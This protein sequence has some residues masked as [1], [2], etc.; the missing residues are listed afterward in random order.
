MNSSTAGPAGTEKGGLKLPYDE[1]C[2]PAPLTSIQDI[3]AF[4]AA[5]KEITHHFPKP[6]RI[7]SPLRA[8]EGAWHRWGIA[9][10]GE[11]REELIRRA[12]ECYEKDDMECRPDTHERDSLREYK[13][14]IAQGKVQQLQAH[15]ANIVKEAMRVLDDGMRNFNILDIASGIG[16]DSAAIVTAL[17]G[18]QRTEG[19]LRRTAFHLVDYSDRLALAEKNLRE[20]EVSTIPHAMSDERFLREFA[21]EKSGTFDFVVM[22]SHLHKKPALSSYLGSVRK[23]LGEGGLFISADWHSLMPQSPADVY[24]ILQD[25]GVGRNGLNEFRRLLGPLMIQTMQETTSA[26]ELR[27]LQDHHSHWKKIM[28]EV[29]DRRYGAALKVR[30]ISAFTT[31]Q[32]LRGELSHAGFETNRDRIR[33]AFPGATLPERLPLQVKA[34]VDTAAVTV[35]LKR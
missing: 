19:L 32:Q 6:I 22:S 28:G 16:R 3:I 29:G 8:W 24:D 9:A 12:N 2:R 33:G 31:T 10:T 21:P 17:R 11:N 14:R 15:L 5:L 35:A 34:H 26:E 13:R 20:L 27:A 30:I 7:G 18:D 1:S 23:I 25:L 4:E